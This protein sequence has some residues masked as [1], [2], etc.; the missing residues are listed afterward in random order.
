M[1]I[2]LVTDS[3]AVIPQYRIQSTGIEVVPV[4]INIDDET[5]EEGEGIHSQAVIS[6]IRA[7]K[8]VSTSRPTPTTF[9]ERYRKLNAA[10]FNE[11][12]SIHLSADLSGTFEAAVLGAQQSHL[13]VQVVDS[14][15]VGLALGFSVLAAA[16]AI[17]AGADIAAASGIARRTSVHSRTWVVVEDLEQLRRG[18]RVG[19]AAALVGS[20]L[21]VKPVL[22]VVSGKVVPIEKVR[23]TSRAH[24]RIVELAA[25]YVHTFGGKFQIGLQH[26]GALD[27]AASIATKL[28]KLLPGVPIITT[29]LGAVLTSHVGPGAIAI[30][31]APVENLVHP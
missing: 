9:A 20:A 27:K 14:R 2:A 19:A 1:A 3:T 5:Y 21:A 26:A 31:A 4:L 6:A 18:G 22:E 28:G 8:S 12:L 15:T 10:G 7:G 11:I 23:T 16:T 25:K 17:S 24:D 29:D 30:T 13:P